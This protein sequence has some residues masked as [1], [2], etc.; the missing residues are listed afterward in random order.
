[1]VTLTIGRPA[2]NLNAWSDQ[3]QSMTTDVRTR[4]IENGLWPITKDKVHELTTNEQLVLSDWFAVQ[5]LSSANDFYQCQEGYLDDETCAASFDAANDF[6]IL[7]MH[8]VDRDMRG[9]RSSFIA[10]MGRLAEEA[11]LPVI[12][13]DG[14]WD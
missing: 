10:E 14:R 5:L 7:G 6:L 13:E 1:M 9:H 11:G 12:R 8:A 3:K 2:T 4:L